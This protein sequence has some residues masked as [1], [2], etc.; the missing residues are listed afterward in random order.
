M[1]EQILNTSLQKSVRCEKDFTYTVTPFECFNRWR[2]QAAIIKLIRAVLAQWDKQQLPRLL[3]LL[4]LWRLL[5]VSSS[6][7]EDQL[8]FE[9]QKLC[10]A[11]PISE[12]KYTSTVLN[13]SILR[14]IIFGY[15][16]EYYAFLIQKANRHFNVIKFTNDL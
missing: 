1:C 2:F 16:S 3:L 9:Y 12:I 15:C 8:R 6:E 13:F 10:M 5:E 7:N 11:A 14:I 4:Q